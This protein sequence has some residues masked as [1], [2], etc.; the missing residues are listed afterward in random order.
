MKI[1]RWLTI[2]FFGLL[3]FNPL[4]SIGDEGPSEELV[5]L[6]RLNES[7]FYQKIDLQT[8]RIL[9]QYNNNLSAPEAT[10]LERI[11]KKT[12]KFLKDQNPY[13]HVKDLFVK[14]GLGVGVTAGISEFTTIIVLPAILTK[15]GLPVL[16]GISAGSPSFLATVPIY[17]GIKSYINKRKLSKKLGLKRLGPLDKLRDELLGHAAKTRLLSVL[18]GNGE[19]E[20][21]LHVISRSFSKFRQSPMGN[22]VDISELK[23]ILIRFESSELNDLLAEIAG[24]N[25]ALYAHLVIK[26]IHRNPSSLTAFNQ[27]M[28][29]KAKE[30][31]QLPMTS[32]QQTQLLLIHEKKLVIEK[33]KED[34]RKLSSLLKKE[35][36]TQTDKDA[37]KAWTQNNIIDLEY[38]DFDISRHEYNFLVAIHNGNNID[39]WKLTDSHLLVVERLRHLSS[40]IEEVN[41]LVKNQESVVGEELELI[42]KQNKSWLPLRHVISSDNTCKELIVPFI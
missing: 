22:I 7:T 6:P 4:S 1:K 9:R 35:A 10:K 3:L 2:L 40:H 5:T 23:T 39:N 36:I 17:L 28:K 13:H 24:D 37:V 31:D 19:D 32:H 33:K 38:L 29:E 18:I 27:L 12:L 42:K 21:E 14:H 16:A 26:Q 30:L 15:A 20:R 8:Q 34:L 11:R 25:K 41:I